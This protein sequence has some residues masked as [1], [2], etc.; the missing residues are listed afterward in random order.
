MTQTKI[1]VQIFSLFYFV[2][3][4]DSMK[5]HWHMQHIKICVFSKMFS[6]TYFDMLLLLTLEQTV[7]RSMEQNAPSKDSSYFWTSSY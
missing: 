7:P 2:C 1:F 3:L 4:A 6:R 5:G